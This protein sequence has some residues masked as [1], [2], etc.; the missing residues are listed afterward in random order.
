MYNIKTQLSRVAF[1]DL[2]FLR[3]SSSEY[4]Q[5]SQQRACPV[6]ATCYFTGPKQVRPTAKLTIVW[7]S[8]AIRQASPRLPREPSTSPQ[9]FTTLIVCSQQ[10]QQ[11]PAIYPYIHSRRH[12]AELRRGSDMYS[13]LGRNFLNFL[14]IGVPQGRPSRPGIRGHQS[15]ISSYLPTDEAI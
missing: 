14:P 6:C 8:P 7:K 3:I 2:S 1:L 9:H 10:Q 11:Q 12:S 15:E 4:V 5:T 13:C